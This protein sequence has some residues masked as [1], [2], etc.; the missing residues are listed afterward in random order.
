MRWLC[1]PGA[2][3]C[4]LVW[5]SLR[6]LSNLYIIFRYVE[7]WSAASAY[8]ICT[9]HNIVAHR[10]YLWLLFAAQLFTFLWPLF[11]FWEHCA[12]QC[13]P[14]SHQ[15][16]RCTVQFVTCL[17]FNFFVAEPNDMPLLNWQVMTS[18]DEYTLTAGAVANCV[19]FRVSTT[20]GLRV[21][22]TCCGHV[23]LFIREHKIFGNMKSVEWI[24]FDKSWFGICSVCVCAVCMTFETSHS[25]YV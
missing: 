13:S 8:L 17:R 23:C 10:L 14:P 25:F 9:K 4:A 22:F 18:H 21:E 3:A 24:I 12:C 19:S 2:C 11:R 20:M 6:A 5:V 1:V 7:I 16:E 15:L